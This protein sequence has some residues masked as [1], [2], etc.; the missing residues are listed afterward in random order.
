MKLW[1][2]YLLIMNFAGFVLMGIDKHKARKN[3]WRIPERVL[4]A[5]ALLGG[6]IGSI[7]GM[8]FF[9]HKT[10]HRTFTIGMPLILF[11]QILL[12]CFTMFSPS[13]PEKAVKQELDLIKRLDEKTITSFISYEDMMSSGSASSDI[14]PET[15]DAVK[16]FFKKFDYEILETTITENSA[17][18]HVQ[19]TNLDTYA[20]ARDVCLALVQQNSGAD[21]T[22]PMTL[23]SYFAILGNVLASNSYDLVTRDAQIELI[24]SEDDWLIQNTA[25]LEDDLISGF[26]T[27]LK[28]PYLV[29]PEEMITVVL[30]GLTE[31][32]PDEW[33]TYLNM[34]DIFSTYSQNYEKTDTALANQLSKY[35]DYE[36]LSVTEDKEKQSATATI[37]ITSLDMTQVMEEYQVL[38]MDYASTTESVRAS[39][40]ELADKTALLL[41]QALNANTATT[42]TVIEIPFTNNGATW[43][44]QLNEDFTNALL[45][46]AG[47]AI[48]TF[49]SESSSDSSI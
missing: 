18:V 10:Q 32:T 48:E 35:V 42:D 43:E 17:V 14:G 31:K 38:L 11:I 15:T 25:Q 27:Y 6:S 9:R 5:A 13:G 1:I 24:Q 47:E 41:E 22:E 33:K 12:F 16:L 20:L 4:F 3:L 37:Q 30:E 8:R 2:I 28:D 39:S 44:M 23:N 40:S 36:I 46:N 34:E 29:T 26:I 19:I 49:Q 7:L 45:G 21:N